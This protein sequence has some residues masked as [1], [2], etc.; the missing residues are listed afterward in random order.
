MTE[1]F[2]AASIQELYRGA[3]LRGATSVFDIWGRNNRMYR[4]TKSVDEAILIALQ[5][6]IDAI[7]D[8]QKSKSSIL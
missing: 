8:Q 1:L 4:F 6:N 2:G 3:F 5:N 7:A